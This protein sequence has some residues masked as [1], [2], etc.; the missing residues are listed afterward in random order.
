MDNIGMLGETLGILEKGEYERDGRRVGLKLTRREALR[1][2]VF[3]P[4]AVDRLRTARLPRSRSGEG[5]VYGCSNRD[6]FSAARALTAGAEP[7]RERGARREVLVLNFANPVRPGGGVRS[8]AS[9]QEED[10]CRKSSLLPALEGRY[11]LPYY[12]YNRDRDPYVGSDAVIIT[13][14]VEILRDAGGGLL[15]D[16]VVAA[17]MTCAAPVKYGLTGLTVQEYRRLLA[18]RIEGML[19]CA[20]HM[21]YTLLVLGAFGCGAFGNDARDVS[22]AFY[23]VLT[24]P[25][26]AGTGQGGAFRRVEF[27]VLDRSPDQYNFN[28]FSRRFAG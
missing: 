14:R 22:E 3:L 6:S 18:R 4:D 27:A 23:R 8:G 25:D 20:A 21:R 12:R 1:C 11:A 15:E 13:P 9:A 24:G 26:L 10:L 17:V 7:F 2:R 16:T 19:R 5:C 28:E